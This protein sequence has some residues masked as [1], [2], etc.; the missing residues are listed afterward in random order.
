V[1]IYA[2]GHL[3]ATVTVDSKGQWSYQ[4]SGSELSEGINNIDIV[5]TDKAG[6]SATTSGMITL[7]TIPPETPV[8]L[9]DEASDTGMSQDDHLTYDKT[10]SLQGNAEPDSKLELYLNGYKVA[11]IQ[12]DS[13]GH[14][15]YTLPD[16]KITS[17]GVYTFEVVASDRAGNTSSASMDITVDTNIDAFSMS[18]NSSSDSG[19][20]GDNY[21]NN[22]SPSFSGKTDPS[23]H[24]VV[25]NL[26]T[27]EVIEIDASQS[28]YFSFTLAMASIEGINEL[29]ISV[30]DYAGNEQTFSYEYTIDTVAPVA[31]DLS[32]DQYVIFPAMF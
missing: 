7:D 16:N 22:T 32:L 25:T 30:T 11:D 29:S 31:P 20:A 10:P 23:S 13:A 19:I 1:S 8:I 2:N 3:L 12:V 28:G 15:E 6:N 24:I 21:T 18:M 5:A 14:W 27:G 4:F 26:M 17:D 9:L